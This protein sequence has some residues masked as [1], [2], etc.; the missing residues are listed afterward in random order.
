[1]FLQGDGVWLSEA[2]ASRLENVNDTWLFRPDGDARG[3]SVRGL[4]DVRKAMFR[5]REL[6]KAFAER[7]VLTGGVQV[8]A[9]VFGHVVVCPV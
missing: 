6:G 1:V 8:F 5:G 9:D 3:A 2:W 7:Y 4:G